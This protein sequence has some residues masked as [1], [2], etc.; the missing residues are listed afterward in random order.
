MASIYPSRVPCR[1]VRTRKTKAWL[2]GSLLLVD[3]SAW[4]LPR[5]QRDPRK[6]PAF[7]LPHLQSLGAHL[8]RRKLRYSKPMSKRRDHDLPHGRGETIQLLAHHLHSSLSA[9]GKATSEEA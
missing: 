5:S 8:L 7:C 3:V 6:K 2:N 9:A 4:E 1:P